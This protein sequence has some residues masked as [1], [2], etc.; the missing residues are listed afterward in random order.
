MKDVGM[1]SCEIGGS[2]REGYEDYC[3]L[4]RDTV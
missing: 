1:A 3:P 4:V 2:H